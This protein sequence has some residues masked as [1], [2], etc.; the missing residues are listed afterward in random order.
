[1]DSHERMAIVARL[2][3]I[4]AEM[5]RLPKGNSHS[6]RIVR[7]QHLLTERDGLQSMLARAQ[8]QSVHAREVR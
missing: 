2:G 4:D 7:R 3:E 8:R 5:E 6:R 1:M